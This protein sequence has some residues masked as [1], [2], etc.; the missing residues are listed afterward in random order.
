MRVIRVIVCFESTT[1]NSQ[2]FFILQKRP[3][4]IIVDQVLDAILRI[5]EG[6]F[7]EIPD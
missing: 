6:N 1:R 5:N 2:Q 7:E 4:Y 3:R